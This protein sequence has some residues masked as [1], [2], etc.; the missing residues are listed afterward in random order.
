M[1]KWIF[2]AIGYLLVVIIGYSVYA[3]FSSQPVE[4][5][6]VNKHEGH[7]E[8]GSNNGH[9]DHGN[10]G[11]SEEHKESEVNVE[12][13]V[14]SAKL[15]ILL[16]DKENQ[17]VEELEI[18]HEK[19]LHLII[20]DEHLEQY[21]HLH[22]EEV[23]PGIYEVDHQLTD[24]VY[25][26]FVDIKPKSLEYVTKP[27]E[28]TIGEVNEEHSHASLQVDTELQREVN[29]VVTILEPSSLKA[30]EPVTLSYTF[31]SNPELQPY[32]GA[33]GHVVILDESGTNYIHVHP[34]SDNET[35]FETLFPAAGIYKIWGEFQIGE[36]VHVYPFTIEVK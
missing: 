1:K 12:L 23:A 15:N 31:P 33:L 36:E 8:T 28:F 35:I 14:T 16:T 2:S 13:N 21:Y 10:H 4:E 30:N 29:G 32:L 5:T 22:P 26:A 20:V 7:N 6:N 34:L 25:K 11:E 24:G 27:V 9:G 18:N 3:A 17:P 19:L